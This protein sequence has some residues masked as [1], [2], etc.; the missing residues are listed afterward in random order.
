MVEEAARG[1]VVSGVHDPKEPA[2][3]LDLDGH[4]PGP[5][6]GRHRRS[7]DLQRRLSSTVPVYDGNLLCWR[8]S[9]REELL[10]S[11]VLRFLSQ[12]GGKQTLGTD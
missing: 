12:T 2:P 8:G 3:G 6:G 9:S 4:H 11:K 10:H 5:T 7:E 1:P